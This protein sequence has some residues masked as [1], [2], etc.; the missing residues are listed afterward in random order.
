MCFLRSYRTSS[1]YSKNVIFEYVKWELENDRSQHYK[2]EETILASCSREAILGFTTWIFCFSL[3]CFS[4]LSCFDVCYK[5]YV[6][7]HVHLVA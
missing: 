4:T 1:R 2:R 7:A 5:M 6:K 3:H